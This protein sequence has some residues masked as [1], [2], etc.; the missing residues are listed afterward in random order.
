MEL[1]K[2][3]FLTLVAD[4]GSNLWTG[5]TWKQLILAP[6]ISNSTRTDFALNIFANA[7]IIAIVAYA[8][9]RSI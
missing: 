4:S 2:F 9:S 5:F 6:D 7:I 8:C 1:S 3:N